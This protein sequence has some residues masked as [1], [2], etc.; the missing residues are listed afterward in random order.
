MR[1]VNCLKGELAVGLWFIVPT[2]KCLWLSAI[3]FVLFISYKMYV[4]KY[5]EK[6]ENSY[7]IFPKTHLLLRLKNLQ[8]IREI[9]SFSLQ[10][11]GTQAWSFS[12]THYFWNFS[13]W[14][15]IAKMV[16]MISPGHASINLQDIRE[17]PSKKGIFCSK[18][19]PHMHHNFQ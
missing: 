12:R 13:W 18:K 2:L 10:K 14:N 11:D 19:M 3:R 1:Q 5:R 16:A 15:G 7:A 9:P 17:I 6:L 4:T 8:D